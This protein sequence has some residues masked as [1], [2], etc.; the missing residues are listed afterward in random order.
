MS[1]P[2]I[3]IIPQSINEGD[4]VLL[5]GLVKDDAYEF[6]INFVTG[7]SPNPEDIAYHFKT[8][9]S[10]NIVVENSKRNGD[11]M[12]EQVKEWPVSDGPLKVHL[13]LNYTKFQNE[14]NSKSSSISGPGFALEF[15]FT[16]GNVYTYLVE[17][18]HSRNLISYYPLDY[19]L[20]EIDS[21]QV[22][23]DVEKIQELTFRY[24]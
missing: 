3:A 23:G 2:F 1:R 7:T 24:S 5:K 18:E 8:I 19:D 22:W 16:G 15:A 11:W 17:D 13:A 12:D 10:E 9:F 4:K 20:H 21:V 14:D 6:S